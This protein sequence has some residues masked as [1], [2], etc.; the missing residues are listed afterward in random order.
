MNSVPLRY[1]RAVEGDLTERDWPTEPSEELQTELA[2]LRTQVEQ[3][4]PEAVKEFNYHLETILGVLDY[5]NIERIW[6]E[7]TVCT[8]RE[9][10]QKVQWGVFDLHVIRSIDEG[11]TYEDAIGPPLGKRTRGRGP[12]VRARRVPRP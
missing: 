12:G 1:R 4:G 11:T 3:L 5:A 8:V 2:D 9:G 10:R 7:R 6:I